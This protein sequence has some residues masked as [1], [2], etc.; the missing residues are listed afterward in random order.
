MAKRY[1]CRACNKGCGHGI[2]YICDQT[3]S[4][5][6]TSPSCAFVSVRIR[7]GDCN[8][9]F[10]SPLCYDNHKKQQL[11]ADRIRKN[12]VNRKNVAVS[13][14]SLSSRKTRLNKQ[15]CEK[16]KENEE[17]G[18][19]CFMRPL[20]KVLPASDRVLFLFQD[21]QTTQNTEYSDSATVHVPNLVCLQQICSICGN[22]QDINIGLNSA[23]G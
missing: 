20:R 17:V 2:R 8:R 10:R 3:C 22:I 19:L 23:V 5:C 7:C 11:G 12:Y 1:A 13:A 6:M 16:C 14:V 4:D 21:I 18:H 9:H 15:W